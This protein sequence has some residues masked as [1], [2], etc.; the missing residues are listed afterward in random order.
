[1]DNPNRTYRLKNWRVSATPARL[2]V[3]LAI[4][5]V[6]RTVL[7]TGQR[8]VYPFLPSIARGLGVELGTVALVVTARSGLG[9]L[10]PLAGSL[11]DTRGRKQAML[12]GLFL[13]ALGMLLIGLRPIFAFFLIGLLLGGASKLFFDPAV[14]AY[15]G[16]RVQYARRGQAIAI[17]ELGWSAA[18]LVGVP[19]AGWLIDRSGHWYAPFPWVAVLAALCG[20]VV[21]GLVPSDSRAA[22]QRIPL[23]RGLGSVLAHRS[24]LAGMLISLLA[25]ASNEM[26]TIVYGAWMEDA[27]A[28][29]VAALGAASAVIGLAELSAEGLVVG[30]VDRLGKRRAVA[31]GLGLNALAS[32]VL[33]WS[34]F[35]VTGAL[36]GLFVFF[37][38][39]E[40]AVVSLIPLMTELVPQARAT[41][42]A[43]N[44]AAFSAGRMLGALAGP[45][46]FTAGLWANGIAA[47]GLNLIALSIVIWFLRQD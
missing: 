32:L 35:A 38:T 20:I 37:L 22:V 25:S 15:L 41:L 36:A 43:S 42:M 26:I 2:R 18:F 46:L 40:F 17:T 6:S 19:L 16:D 3:Q 45:L 14:Q 27:F 13:F 9:I 47:A 10:S 29:K 7:N 4:F 34:G 12:A 31:W 39:F 33:P 1:M 5:S 24:A 28:L 8:M 23:R 44:V 11:A 21:W 30:V